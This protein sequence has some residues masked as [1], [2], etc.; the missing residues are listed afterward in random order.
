MPLHVRLYTRP[1]CTLCEDALNVVENLRDD[2]NFLLEEVNIDEDPALKE[3]L[4]HQ[5]PV[6]TVDGGNKITGDVTEER[7]RRAFNRARKARDEAPN[8]Q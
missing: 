1:G 4:G 6:I 7:V 3:R 8:Q 5:I 2:F